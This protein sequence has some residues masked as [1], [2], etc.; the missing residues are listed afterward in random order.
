LDSD[1]DVVRREIK[2]AYNTYLRTVVP[3]AGFKPQIPCYG[4]IIRSKLI[5]AM[6]DLRITVTW[7]PTNDPNPDNRHAVCRW[8]RWDDQTLMALL[9]RQP[10]ELNDITLAQPQHQKRFAL[11]EA[12]DYDPT[13]RQATV[14]FPLRQ[15]YMKGLQPPPADGEWLPI[16][17]TTLPSVTTP[18]LNQTTRGLEITTMAQSVNSILTADKTIYS[19]KVPNSVELG[20]ELNDPC[21]FFQIMPR[22]PASPISTTP[23]RDRQLYVRAS[24]TAPPAPTTLAA[25]RSTAPT[26]SPHPRL[27]APAHAAQ[28][29]TR[30]LPRPPNQQ[31]KI[32][33]WPH[34]ALALGPHTALAT[35]TPHSSATATL[36]TRF[37]LTVF[38]DYK[39]PPHRF[40]QDKYS[41]TDYLATNNIYF[42]DLIFSIRKKSLATASQYQLLKIVIDIPVASNPPDTHTEALLTP[43]Y[44]GPGVRMLSNQ[45]FIPFLFNDDPGKPLHVELVP[46]STADD[47]AIVLNDRKT[48]ELGFRLAEANVGPVVVTTLVDIDGERERQPRGKVDITMTEWYATPAFP[49][50]EAVASRYTVIKFATTDDVD[51]G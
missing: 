10:E 43:T 27:A 30:Q 7:K 33:P 16:Q 26:P 48:R 9:D 18:W 29:A 11:G 40:P 6:P 46:R 14:T 5:K 41:P 4:F 15:L 49:K 42:Y 17:P 50:G 32:Q 24:S 47:Y 23:Q 35:P 45:R 51:V 12:I 34:S 2:R 44:D 39:G 36:Q 19:E 25:P 37:D 31:L 22:P 21:Y 20:L 8:T 38:A 1:D 28:S 13:T 3:D